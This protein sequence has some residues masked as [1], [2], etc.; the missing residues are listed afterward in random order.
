MAIVG[1]FLSWFLLPHVGHR[2][3]YVVGLAIMFSILVTVGSMGIPS[4]QASLGWA[5]G[6]LLMLFVIT[7][8]MT[9]RPVCY[10]LVAEIP[11]TRLRIKTVAMARNAYLL[12]SIGANFLNPPILNPSAWNLRDKGGFIWAGLCFL[13]L[14]WAYF[15]LP[16]PKSRSSAE[17]EMLFE[18]GVSARKFSSN[19]VEVFSS[20]V[21]EKNETST[22]DMI[23]KP[24]ANG[25]KQGG[26]SKLGCHNNCFESSRM[27]EIA[28][29]TTEE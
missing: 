10:C 2:T 20:Q 11:S 29:V 25:V 13:E 22:L 23:E 8:D 21:T 24:R 14:V 5:A 27:P 15:C 26:G 12:V 18:Q 3:L 1:T 19:T 28:V 9:V 16:E 6:S 7:Y 4:P 17:L